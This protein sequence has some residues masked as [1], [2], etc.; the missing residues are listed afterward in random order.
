MYGRLTSLGEEVPE[1]MSGR[2]GLDMSS[3][4]P[5]MMSR[6]DMDRP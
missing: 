3:G 5:G 4:M 2:E 1:D 6:E